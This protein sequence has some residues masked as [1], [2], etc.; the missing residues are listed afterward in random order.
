MEAV[1][2]DEQ[3]R[4]SRRARGRPRAYYG[5][6][7]LTALL[8]LGAPARAEDRC[9]VPH[10]LL[11][12]DGDLPATAAALARKQPIKIVA[13]GSAATAGAGASGVDAAFP[14][15]L[16][17]HLAARLPGHAVSVVNKGVARRSAAE[18]SAHLDAEVLSERPTLVL[19]E[20]GTVDAVRGIEVDGFSR[21]L[22][23]GVARL[24]A[25]GAD[26][27]LIE[28]QYSPRTTTLMNL[29]PYLEAV[30]M[31]ADG[32]RVDLFRRFDIMRH[33][34]DQGRFDMTLKPPPLTSEIDAVYDCIGRL[35]AQLIIE[36][37]IADG[38]T[39]LR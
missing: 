3:R 9:A 13:L 18:M 10:E 37:L 36:R 22:S 26:V 39:G 21:T 38:V 2:A 23:D 15:R 1:R 6:L 4:A 7:A 8:A 5:A 14:A 28:P 33:W 32:A 34:M 27:I 29:Q 30:H 25:A 35:I 24:K 12:D 17:M 31:V 19:W 20:A 11:E 16:R